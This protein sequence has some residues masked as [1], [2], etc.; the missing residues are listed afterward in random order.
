MEGQFT[1]YKITGPEGKSYIGYTSMTLSERW[2]H[3]KL[4][5]M[6]KQGKAASE[7]LKRWWAD[8][9]ADPERY[10]EYMDRRKNTLS[11][12]LKKKATCKNEDI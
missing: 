3:H 1:I 5:A 10:Q 7:G 9:K 12:T 6:N 2:R 8:L 11:K 4:R